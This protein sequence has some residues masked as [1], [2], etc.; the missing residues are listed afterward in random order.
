M[1]MVIL[2][3]L[4]H[5]PIWSTGV[6]VGLSLW[7]IYG[8]QKPDL[9]PGRLLLILVTLG[10]VGLHIVFFGT[11]FGQDVGVSLLIVMSGLK[12]ME[13]RSKRDSYMVI[14]L[15]L[16]IVIT[17]F[18]YNQEIILAI[19]LFAALLALLACMI[20][21]SAQAQSPTVKQQLKLSSILLL[22]A[23]PLTIVLFVFFPRVSA[24]WAI[25]GG[26]SGK[27]GLS[28]EMSPGQISN[29]MQNTDPAFRVTFR[30]EIPESE[31]RYWRAI[32][33]S[34]YDG[35]T[36]RPNQ[37]RIQSLR[38][39]PRR[40]LADPS[41][42]KVQLEPHKGRWLVGLDLPAINPAV[43]DAHADYTL[44]SRN[45]VNELLQ[46][47]ATSYL[48][49]HTGNISRIEYQQSLQL[50]HNFSPKVRLLAKKWWR[51][52]KNSRDYVDKVLK[53]F[54][55][56]NFIYTLTPPRLTGDATE[57][58]L[59]DSKKGF[60]EHYSSAFTLL[61]RAAGIP[62]RV[63]TGYQGGDFNEL[64]GYLIVRQSDAHA[65]SEVWLPES[66]WTRV[67]PTAAVAPERIEQAI[68][69]EDISDTG[70]ILF[71]AG[72]LGALADMLKQMGYGLD[73]INHAWNDWFIS[74]D[75]ELQKDF[76][77]RFGININ[78]WKDLL[79]YLFAGVGLV[80]A[81]MFYRLLNR[82][83]RKVAEIAPSLRIYQQFCAKMAVINLSKQANEG[84][85]DYQQ[86]IIQRYPELDISVSEIM[87][88]YIA[89]RYKSLHSKPVLQQ[90]KQRVAEFQPK[91]MIKP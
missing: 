44:R 68:N 19:Y 54:N 60:C 51:T 9:L 53:H 8:H 15:G 13:S 50:P 22:Q 34:H 35:K 21:L 56:E 38:S 83:D 39:N 49:Y 25:P 17:N 80:F 28:E 61:M 72:E 81:F 63:V 91:K 12:I 55:Q 27:T 33:L 62:A 46:Y 52:S 7:R 11:L 10:L 18:L 48:T 45:P 4:T 36:W 59:F 89:L 58:F 23:L 16:F 6:F 32:I 20:E 88:L 75:S 77:S 5:V 30:G 90:F 2:P 24:L 84:P 40:R 43:G 73:A 67:D 26:S 41:Y 14:F 65:W 74:Y 85:S 47:E 82:C 76:L 57:Q 69:F 79:W 31:Q 37:Q 64:G 86:R 1:S 66:G 70:E 87:K 42:Y 29:L 78:H 3:H 71:T